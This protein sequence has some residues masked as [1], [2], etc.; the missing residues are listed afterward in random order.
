MSSH[1]F[2]SHSQK[3]TSF[4]NRML[5]CFWSCASCITTLLTRGKK[6]FLLVKFV[7][8]CL[9]IQNIY[10]T[11]SKPSIC[12]QIASVFNICSSPKNF[13]TVAHCWVQFNS[14]LSIIQSSRRKMK[15]FKA[16]LY[17]KDSHALFV[18]LHFNDFTFYERKPFYV[19]LFIW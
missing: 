17:K 2:G 18:L 4:T 15:S 14:F 10:Q 8:L 16:E 12:F 9:L 5:H 3:F 11:S 6:T 13:H 1:R 19:S 7:T